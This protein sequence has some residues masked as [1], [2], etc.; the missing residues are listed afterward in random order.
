MNGKVLRIRLRIEF[1]L[2]QYLKIMK[3]IYFKIITFLLFLVIFSCVKN[4]SSK[5]INSYKNS[6]D[7]IIIHAKSPD[8]SDPEIQK[9][10]TKR[11]LESYQLYKVIEEA[12]KND[13]PF[14]D[15]PKDQMPSKKC[16]NV[17]NDK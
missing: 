4:P 2:T 1:I 11:D 6:Q 5:N 17:L 8:I 16:L 15:I 10:C 12:Q 13:L 7:V 9:N 3:N 14:N